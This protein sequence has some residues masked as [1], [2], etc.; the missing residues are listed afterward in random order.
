MHTVLKSLSRY[1]FCL[2]ACGV[3]SVSSLPAQTT[4]TPAADPAAERREELKNQA[5]EA[6][7][8]GDHARAEQ[9][10]NQVLTE[11]PKDHVALYLRGS[12]RVELGTAT[13]DAA[14]VR[15]GIS[16]ARA[17]LAQEFNVDYY[18]PYLYGMSRLA[19]VEGRPE[20]SSSGREVADK[21]LSMNKANTEQQANIYFQRSLL[22]TQLGDNAAAKQ[23]LQ[24]AIQL[25]PKHLAS[26]TALCNLVL[27]EGNAQAAE[28]QFDAT[29][30]AIPDQPIVFNNRGSFLQQQ[31]RFDEAIRDFSK[32]IELDANYVP[33]LTNR[34]YVEILQE[35]YSAAE[36]DLT[37]S[38]ELDPRQPTAFN[39]RAAAR[40]N[41]GQIAGAIQDLQTVAQLTPDVAQAHFDLGFAHFYDRNYPAARQEFDRAMQLDP[42]IPFLAPWRYTAM[43]FSEQRDQAVSEFGAIERKPEDQRSW[44]D[45]LTLLLMGK[46]NEDVVFA[47][48][49][50]STPQT[51]SMQ[52]CE[53]NYFVGLRYASRNKPEEASKFFE[54]ALTTRQRHLAAF[55][56]AMYASKQFA[57]Q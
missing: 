36:V 31:L 15:S 18:L 16:D 41:L 14:M 17:A 8:V 6:Y 48:I 45:I 39:L 25:A 32:A 29:I 26:Q 27:G 35:K 2:M 11:N 33:A 5:D 30:A 51:K 28:A 4:S 7:R 23:D 40:I 3:L 55:R 50:N 44:F 20:H 49:D 22:D 38:L 12:A 9:L 56:G 46:V 1:L 37:K 42:S 57:P 13:N 21:V 53:A 24:K 34:G 43:V 10:L 19:I 52:E 54:K 47:S